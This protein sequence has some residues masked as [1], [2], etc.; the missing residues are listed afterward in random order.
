MENIWFNIVNLHLKN[1]SQLLLRLYGEKKIF[2]F[3]TLSVVFLLLKLI[4]RQRNRNNVHFVNVMNVLRKQWIYFF[5]QLCNCEMVVLVLA[6]SGKMSYSK[7]QIMVLLILL[8][9]YS[10]QTCSVN[11]CI[12]MRENEGQGGLPGFSPAAVNF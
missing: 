3:P 4:L 1:A 7:Q 5:F 8:W 11:C 2:C 12:Q 6:Q 10:I 9:G